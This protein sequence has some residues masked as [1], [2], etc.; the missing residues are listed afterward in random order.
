MADRMIDEVPSMCCERDRVSQTQIRVALTD[1][2]DDFIT[3]R[4]VVNFLRD[5]IEDGDRGDHNTR[6]KILA[7]A[8][9]ARMELFQ[10]DLSDLT[11]AAGR[12]S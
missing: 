2:E 5:T 4:F 8:L 6:T 10:S 1:L 3:I 9:S 12:V 7:D 11:L